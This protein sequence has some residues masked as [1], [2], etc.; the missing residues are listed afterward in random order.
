M[1]RNWRR[2]NESLVKRGEVY[3]SFDFL[4]NWNHEI[5]TMNINKRG[6][7][8]E[9]P[10]SF[11]KSTAFIR[12]LFSLQYRQTEG[13]LRALSKYIK[14]KVADYTTLWRRIANTEFDVPSTNLENS[15]IAID[16]TG[17]KV[18]NRGEWMREKWKH[19]WM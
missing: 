18:T 5:R 9:F 4:D 14:F 17:M 15:V 1:K 6:R 11:I 8:Y 3:L 2:Y 10:N 13:I 7:P 16:S 12:T 19:R